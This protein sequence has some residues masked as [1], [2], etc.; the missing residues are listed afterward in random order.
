[1]KIIILLLAVLWRQAHSAACPNECSGN[2][3]CIDPGNYC[4]C[5]AGYTAPDCSERICA[6][7]NAWVDMAQG[8]DN[9]HNMAE[10]S[11]MGLCTRSSGIC[12]CRTGFEGN[13]CQ[14][15]SCPNACNS[16]G[17]CQSMQYYAS[18]KD[19]GLGTVFPY[20]DIW[21]A[22]KMHGCSCDEKYNGP[23]C[24]L[25]NCSRGDDPL[26]GVGVSTAANPNQ[27]N[28]IQKVTCKAGGGTF[29]ITF[30]KKTSAPIPY[31]AKATE[32]QAYLEA[33][34]TIGAGNINLIMYSS[35]ACKDAG[36]S[37]TVEFKGA[38][39]SLPL[40]T[41]DITKLTFSDLLSVPYIVVVKQVDGTKE[42][43]SCSGRGI[44]DTTSGVCSCSTSYATSNGYNL[45][46]TRGDCGYATATIQVCPGVL[47]C[48]GH[49][50]CK[51]NPTYK[52]V[53]QD[54]YTGADCSLRFVFWFIQL[55]ITSFS[56]NI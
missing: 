36:V 17:K 10:C 44:C 22:E 19:P 47:A 42:S 24:S 1:M 20:T 12:S 11:N 8:V 2:G 48:S 34:P 25:R 5:F 13:A 31:D 53:C 39:G 50:Q 46:G 28:E 33:I 32:L 40:L 38:F 49:G 52:C 21:D 27:V 26:T 6:F 3:R 16:A 56:H 43:L 7:G 29:T 30:R 41:G 14:R 55:C 18:R 23:D 37:W 35:Q 45:P 9:A 15:K 54:G 4:Q 51:G